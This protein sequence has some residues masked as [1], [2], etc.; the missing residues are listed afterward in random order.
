MVST[1]A[2]S[3]LDS[4]MLLLSDWSEGLT[5][6]EKQLNEQRDVIHNEYRTHGAM[7]RLFEQALPAL[8]PN[9]R[10][11]ERTVIGSMDVV[12]HCNSNRLRDYYHKWY[13][14]GNQAIVIVGDIDAKKYEAKVKKLFSTLPV[15]P[16]PIRLRT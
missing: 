3:A 4:C 9:S 2:V 5:L 11:G 14:P 10:Y 8:F 12:D 16:R 1:T 7:Q 6:D 15:R 13:F